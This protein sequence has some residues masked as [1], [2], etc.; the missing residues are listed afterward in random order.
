MQLQL[1]PAACCQQ[2][3]L[4]RSKKLK[5]Q[6]VEPAP[7]RTLCQ[8]AA[9]PDLTVRCR[10][11]LSP[12]V[13]DRLAWALMQHR[14]QLAA[15]KASTITAT[16][17]ATARLG[18]DPSTSVP[19]QPQRPGETLMQDLLALVRP[20]VHLPVRQLPVCLGPLCVSSGSSWQQARRPQSQPA[21][22]HALAW[23]GDPSISAPKQPQRPGETLTQ[24]LLALVRLRPFCSV[25]GS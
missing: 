13:H 1:L 25:P 4:Y 19:K 20:A 10:H 12:R 16:M 18:R 24:Q 23:A 21:R 11:A 8:P 9:G 14:Q 3:A 6:R 22:G 17:W 7:P 2:V 5:L 15:G